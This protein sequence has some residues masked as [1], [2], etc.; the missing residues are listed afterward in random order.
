MVGITPLI[1][2]VDYYSY[3]CCHTTRQTWGWLQWQWGVINWWLSVALL[4]K[5]NGT[6][7]LHVYPRYH[8]SDNC[9][10]ISVSFS[11]WIWWNSLILCIHPRYHVLVYRRRSNK[12]PIPLVLLFL[13]DL[14]PSK[15]ENTFDLMHYCLNVCFKASTIIISVMNFHDNTNR[16]IIIIGIDVVL[17]YSYCKGWFWCCCCCG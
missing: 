9:W 13:V 5:C 14:S 7:S 3:Y 17:L 4:S 1:V 15:K 8:A 2:L 12:F 16:V 10:R 11:V 6:R